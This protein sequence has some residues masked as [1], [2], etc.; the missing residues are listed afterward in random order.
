M[1]EIKIKVQNRKVEGL[2]NITGY[3][4][5][6]DIAMAIL[7]LEA[8]KQRMLEKSEDYEP[9]VEIKEEGK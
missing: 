9:I 4:G 5:L 2:Y 7:E 3:T 6:N 1:I 8:M